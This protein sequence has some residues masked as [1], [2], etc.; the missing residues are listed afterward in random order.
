MVEILRLQTTEFEIGDGNIVNNNNLTGKHRENVT[1]SEQSCKRWII[2]WNFAAGPGCGSGLLRKMTTPLRVRFIRN[3]KSSVQRAWCHANFCSR[4]AAT[5]RASSMVFARVTSGCLRAF[6]LP[7]PSRKWSRGNRFATVPRVAKTDF[8]AR[9]SNRPA[10][11]NQRKHVIW[12]DAGP[13]QRYLCM[14]MHT[15]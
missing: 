5:P 12:P 2:T 7:S 11:R 3:R 1:R 8:H 13:V 6:A 4:I 9:R 14:H 10:I 15:L